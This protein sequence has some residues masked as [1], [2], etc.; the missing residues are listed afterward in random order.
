VR[1]EAP[2]RLDY[3]GTAAPLQDVWIALRA[4]VRAVLEAV[5][6]AHL[7]EGRLPKRVANLAAKDDARLRR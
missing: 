3:T 2:E 7:A 5:T 4:N 6:L 1:G